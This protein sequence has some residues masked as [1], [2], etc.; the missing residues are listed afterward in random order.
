MATTKP[1]TYADLL[2]S[3]ARG[4]SFYTTKTQLQARRLQR[5]SQLRHLSHQDAR[6]P[7]RIGSAQRA[8][9]RTRCATPRTR[10]AGSPP[11]EDQLCETSAG[12]EGRLGARR[13]GAFRQTRD[14]FE[15]E[16]GTAGISRCLLVRL[17]RSTWNFWNGTARS[18]LKQGRR[19]GL[20]RSGRGSWDS[21]R[22]FKRDSGT[23]AWRRNARRRTSR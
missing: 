23:S 3:V 21:G 22:S 4:I 5:K 19:R 1:S 9:K 11:R 13:A 6:P 20:E 7:D 8:R 17:C 10:S 18:A 2:E 14:V 16:L 15:D 12:T